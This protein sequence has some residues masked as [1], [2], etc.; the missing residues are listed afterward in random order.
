M[1]AGEPGWK[2][3]HFSPLILLACSQDLCPV[4]KPYLSGREKEIRG[5]RGASTELQKA[6]I[7]PLLSWLLG[8]GGKKKS[9]II[10]AAPRLNL[11]QECSG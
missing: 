4:P 10:H 11:W 3:R 5:R 9:W 7:G 8:M 2:H 6:R 1:G